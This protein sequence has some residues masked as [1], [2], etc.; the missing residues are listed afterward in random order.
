MMVLLLGFIAIGGA[1]VYRAMRD[2]SPATDRYALESVTLPS[3]ASVISTSAGDGLVTITY[4]L[5]DETQVR[6]LDGTTGETVG[7]FSVKKD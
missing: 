4:R 2:D 3:G 1:L 6:I 5:D 7:Q